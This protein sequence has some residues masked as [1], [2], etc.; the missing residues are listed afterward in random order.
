MA[1]TMRQ[2]TDTFKTGGKASVDTALR[3]LQS[4]MRNN[5]YTSYGYRGK[6]LDE[7][8]NAGNGTLRPALAGQAMSSWRPR[9]IAAAGGATA[10][11]L[12]AAWLAS[13]PLLALGIAP[14]AAAASPRVIGNIT[15]LL[16]EAAGR[17]DRAPTAVK[18]VT[19][20]A[21]AAV[22]RPVRT[23]AAKAQN[24]VM[25]DAQGNRYDI[26]GNLVQ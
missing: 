20:T 6:L 25:E 2:L 19:K 7:L 18:A 22:S 1:D 4:T 17:L 16:G 10:I 11:P 24:W 21:K 9:G 14:F 12:G 23:T 3:R 26:N 15:G 8:D 13:N 5:A